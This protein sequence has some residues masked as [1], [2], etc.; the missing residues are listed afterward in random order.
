MNPILDFARG[1]LFAFCF[2][3]LVL[4]LLR[5]G[6]LAAF[7]VLRAIRRAGDRSIPYGRLIK[8]TLLGLIPGRGNVLFGATSFILH[9]GLVIAPIFLLD[10]ILLW[11][12]GLGLAWPALPKVVADAMTLAT[13]A[14]GIVLLAYRIASPAMRFISGTMDYLLLILVI[15]LFA[16]GFIASRPCS[17]IPYEV[18]MLLHAL[19]GDAL[20]LLIPFTKLA[21]CLLYPIVR[22]GANV[23]WRFPPH[24]GEE[25]TK[26][27][28]GKEVRKV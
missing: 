25:I 16:S 9:I 24:A 6:L 20:L 17:P 14:A 13:L 12:S 23:A 22:V 7:D 21:H 11:R 5:A 1:P 4:G 28:Y 8:D 10:H 19:C 26:A 3:V 2:A 27:L 15:I 18:S